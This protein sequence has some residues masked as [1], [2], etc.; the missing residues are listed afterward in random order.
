MSSLATNTELCLPSLKSLTFH[1]F[2]KFPLQPFHLDTP[3][4]DAA[5]YFRIMTESRVDRRIRWLRDEVN[6]NFKI[7]CK[8]RVWKVDGGI[9]AAESSYFERLCIG[10]FQV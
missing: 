3:R 2:I 1:S 4:L 5:Y 10:G 7:T 9:L 8:G 6:T